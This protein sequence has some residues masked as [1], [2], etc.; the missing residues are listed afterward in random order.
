M[1]R[2]RKN[3][4]LAG[5]EWRFL[6]ENEIENDPFASLVESG[7]SVVRGQSGFAA[8]STSSS[9]GAASSMMMASR[10][11]DPSQDGSQLLATG[12]IERLLEDAQGYETQIGNLTDERSLSANPFFSSV[13]DSVL[14]DDDNDQ[15]LSS[16]KQVEGKEE[17]TDHRNNE[18]ASDSPSNDAR[19]EV[20]GRMFLHGEA[21]TESKQRE[22]EE[23]LEEKGE[24][25]REGSGADDEDGDGAEGD[26]FE[27]NNEPVV[28]WRPTARVTLATD[29]PRD[30]L[31]DL[32][33][34]VRREQ[35]ETRRKSVRRQSIESVAVAVKDETTGKRHS[36][37]GQSPVR[38]S[39]RSIHG[40]KGSA[41][42]I[43]SG[44][45]FVGDLSAQ[46]GLRGQ[47]MKNKNMT[48]G[49]PRA[50]MIHGSMRGTSGGGRSGSSGE[51]ST[52]GS[53]SPRA[54][55]PWRGSTSSGFHYGGAGIQSGG[56]VGDGSSDDESNF[57]RREGRKYAPGSPRLRASYGAWYLPVEEWSVG[58]KEGKV[59][60]RLQNERESKQSIL[61]KLKARD[62]KERIP[63]LPIS[64]RYKEFLLSQGGQ[65]PEFLR[66]V[67]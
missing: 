1:R 29:L 10:A 14:Q 22:R 21:Q 43:N 48:R 32:L 25:E 31:D 28:I 36:I 54:R 64:K 61:L 58:D 55:P 66:D 39:K 30:L 15:H 12:K 26:D 40:S 51:D 38:G 19:K 7:R 35:Q 62:I 2:A 60:K 56:E 52:K 49:S 42:K 57:K 33:R 63:K 50:S 37:L 4:P 41:R 65:L 27:P 34:D 18:R 45:R 9:V 20:L 47:S 23:E 13:F 53:R 24:A 5:V 59:R 8:A 17:E 44:P 6:K 3:R 11:F 46:K 16:D 67:E